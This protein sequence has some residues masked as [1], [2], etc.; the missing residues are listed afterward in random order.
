MPFEILYHPDVK[1]YDLQNID[2]KTREKIKNV[3]EKRLRVAPQHYGKP[4][5]KTLKGYWKLRVGDYR[6]VFKISGDEIWILGI[7][8]RK[9]VY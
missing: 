9:D 2:K 4:L 1:L 8:H 3:I 7:I 6:V 5:R